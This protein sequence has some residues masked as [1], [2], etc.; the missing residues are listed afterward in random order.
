MGDIK[1]RDIKQGDGRQGDIKQGD[2]RQADIKQGDGK[3]GRRRSGIMIAAA[4]SG[5]GKT[6]ISCALLSV[7]KQRG[8][9][10]AAFKCGPDYID[11]MFHRSVIGI[12]SHNLDGF[13]ANEELMRH[14][15]LTGGAENEV[16]VVEGVMGLF[17]GLG[18]VRE[19][20]SSYR[21]ASALRLPVI[22]VVDAYGMGRS[23]L[24][25]IAGFLQYD[26]ERL[27]RGVILNR[28]TESF[29]HAIAPV[30][31]KEL[32]IEVL[33]F[34]PRNQE[35]VINS[36]HLGLQLPDEIEELQKKLA[37]A[38]ELLNDTVDIDKLLGLAWGAESVGEYE[39]CEDYA[40]FVEY[41]KNGGFAEYGRNGSFVECGKRGDFA[42]QG[43]SEDFG[44]DGEFERVRIGI[45]RD[46]AFCFYY[47]ENLRV[48]ELL[49]A[50][51]VP[52]SPLHDARLPEGLR[53]LILGGGYPENY[54]KEL[55]ANESMR[56]C[57]R[58]AIERG[59]PSLAECGGFMYLH[60]TLRDE[61]GNVYSMCGVIDGECFYTGK[62][63][64]FGYVELTEKEPSFMEAGS[65][66]KGHEF[67]Y[68]DSSS[69]GRA[70]DARKPVGERGWECIHSG[71]E[72]FWGFAHLYYLSNVG[73]IA[74]FVD[75]ARGMGRRYYYV[76]N[77]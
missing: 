28:I 14:I 64:R 5:S 42:K 66:I 56:L 2:E 49:G 38:S 19:E 30:I 62:L 15:Y 40:E 16:C 77:R 27:I 12:P 37:R 46:E 65:T 61:H 43:M 67:H 33:G 21:I 48:L 24:P 17:D 25:L 4:G 29:Y 75:L 45:A 50:E 60:N 73:F 58:Q 71:R 6:T 74:H 63:V 41:G 69:N 76:Q 36:R 59:V 9:A 32:G 39:K 22:L 35:L 7:L 26:R 1:Q 31:E 57:I 20:G 51:L 8:M 10:V 11:P 55:E 18:G 47:E 34:L 3:L 54:A 72:H 44:R 23:V 13:F 53:G 68:Y 70:C 52:F